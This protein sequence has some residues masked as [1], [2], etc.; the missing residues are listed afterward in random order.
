MQQSE[1]SIDKPVNSKYRGFSICQNSKKKW[2]KSKLSGHEWSEDILLNTFSIHGPFTLQALHSNFRSIKG[3][4]KEIDFLI[5]FGLHLP[6]NNG[7]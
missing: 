3:A 6:E 4:M 5:K 1:K 7:C 2:F